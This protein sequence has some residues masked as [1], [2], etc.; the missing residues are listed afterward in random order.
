MQEENK[1]SHTKDNNV[2]C[3]LDS[4]S[5]PCLA[6]GL[7]YCRVCVCVCWESKL[8]NIVKGRTKEVLRH[9]VVK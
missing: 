4:I 1:L 2:K 5:D 6:Q 9:K 8:L 3:S 7:D